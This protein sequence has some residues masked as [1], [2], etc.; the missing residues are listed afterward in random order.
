MTNFRFLVCAT[1]AF[2]LSS[3]A[4]QADEH[5]AWKPTRYED[6]L[7]HAPRPVPG[8]VVL[9]WC[10]DPTSTQAVTWRTDV[11]IVR[12]VAEI[13]P[14]N[15]NGR[16]LQ[17]DSVPARTVAFT[18]DLN[19]A[20]FHSV[21]F[22]GLRPETLY[23]YRVGDGLNWSEW[24]HFR[25]ASRE[26]KPFTFVYFGDAQNDLKT[27]WSRVFREAFRDAPRAAFTLHAGDLIN[28]DDSDA[29]WG[30]WHGA[31]AWVNGTVPVIATPGNH[32]YYNKDAGPSTD[33]RW[34]AKDR[35]VVRV[36]VNTRT[37]KDAAGKTTG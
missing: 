5:A 19:E 34:T 6:K 2:P 23:T 32:E 17:P 13:A 30:E 25:T 4:H 21:N 8:R 1:L 29:E 24:F 9:T 15:E 20:H 11:S 10:S 33:R 16:A 28:T 37:E 36:A 27:H 31:P 7:A 22:T 14:A 3:F 26:A 18:S 35:S 12:A